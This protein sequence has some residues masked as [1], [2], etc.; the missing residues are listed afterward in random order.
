MEQIHREITALSAE[1]V[2][3]QQGERDA[4]VQQQ[5]EIMKQAQQ[6]FQTQQVQL[7]SLRAQATQLPITPR[8]PRDSP[9]NLESQ[10]MPSKPMPNG[11]LS[12]PFEAA[13]GTTSGQQ[14]SSIGVAKLVLPDG[15]SIP[16]GS[17]GAAP[18]GTQVPGSSSGSGSQTSQLDAL[19]RSDKWLPS[20][21]TINTSSWKTRTDEIP[22]YENFLESLTLWLGFV[23]KKFSQEVRFAATSKTVIEPHMLSEEQK[24]RGIRLLNILRQVFRDVPRG[25]NHLDGLQRILWREERIRGL[26]ME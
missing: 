7:D 16:L 6:A 21:P 19:Q 11:G 13:A 18:A 4:M 3:E 10:P 22:G 9:F 23:S 24:S 8:K 25:Q 2:I 20:M 14:A 1:L 12:S 17:S 26:E 15:T 5:Q